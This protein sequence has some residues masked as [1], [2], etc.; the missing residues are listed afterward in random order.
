MN[1]RGEIIKQQILELKQ[2]MLVGLR[3]N[4]IP[5]EVSD[6]LF[7]TLAGSVRLDGLFAG[8]DKLLATRGVGGEAHGAGLPFLL[9]FGP[10]VLTRSWRTL[11]R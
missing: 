6:Y 10:M 1:E 4:A 2:E 11:S 5:E 9:Y 7:E 8:R 3:K